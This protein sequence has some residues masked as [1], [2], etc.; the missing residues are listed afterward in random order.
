MAI[1][2]EK[3]QA[4]DLIQPGEAVLPPQSPKDLTALKTVVQDVQ[5][6]EF[7][8]QRKGYSIEWNR[9]ERLYLFEVPVAFWEGTNISR[10]HL[11]MPLV[12]EHVE[13]ILPQLMGSLFTDDPPF[14]SEP[15]PGTSMQAARA[16]DALLAWELE[17][18]GF[19]EELRLT[20]KSALIYGTGIA[21]W[22]WKLT[23][24]TRYEYRRKG[25]LKAET[26]GDVP[27]TYEDK[28]YDKLEETEV[29]EKINLP[30]F[31]SVSLRHVLVDP[32]CRTSDIR[33]AKWVAH[34]LYLTLL[35][36]DALRKD[37]RYKLPSLETMT[38]WFFPPKEIAKTGAQESYGLDLGIHREF[39]AQP[40]AQ[41]ST[42][43]PLQQ[44]LEVLE[45]WT[46]DRVY[47]VIQRKLVVR[48]E[49][50]EFGEI[51]FC[52]VAFCD[53]LDSFYGVGIAKLIGNEQRMQQGIINARLDDLALSLNSMFIRKRGTN[54]PT[55]QLRMRPGG[56]IDTDDDKGVQLL[57][58]PPANVESF[59]EIEA[60]D[61]RAAR[62]TAANEMMTQGSMPSEK[63]SI[64]RTATGVNA[65]TGGTGSRLQYF[66]ENIAFNIFIP[67]LYAFH[68]MN[69]RYLAP[70]QIQSILTDELRIAYKSDV[71]DLVNSRADFSILAAARMQA[72]HAMAQALPLMFQ[73]ILT[74]PVMQALS[75]EGKKVNVVELVNMLFDVTGWRNKQDVIQPMT[76]ED[77]QRMMMN[78]PAVQQAIQQRQQAQTQQTNKLQVL[79]EE[80]AA[81]AGKEVIRSL[82]R[83]AETN[84]PGSPAAAG[85][86]GGI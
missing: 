22:G 8:I 73:F 83:H 74:D 39:R 35:D 10:A 36:L 33:T 63:S 6:G 21:K 52:S 41:I 86:S 11:G 45:Y 51:P 16:N 43:D 40:R 12:Y 24:Q 50:N 76:E 67:T 77:Q 3:P 30:T 37:P 71:V 57:V 13:S 68:K 84:S 18:A 49:P 28:D 27:V 9:Y 60:S 85:P 62:R 75:Q 61:K 69:A 78:N 29:T 79:D 7:W 58:R 4:F 14:I 56:I 19:R 80:N 81:R 5:R 66:V 64:T 54:T 72:K 34:R 59:T 47:T 82:L 53:V 32:G 38:N 31:E 17:Q 2:Q 46:K 25:T 48:N 23:E 55:Q 1:I 42:V 44:P 65:L 20:L 26:V 15:R 70:S